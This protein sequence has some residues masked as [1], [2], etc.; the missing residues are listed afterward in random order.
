MV[1]SGGETQSLHILMFPWFA[2]GHI[3]PFLHI[4]NHL[5]S[6]NHRITFLLPNNPSPLFH[7]LNLYPNLISFHFL[8]LPSVPGLPPAAHSASDIPLSLTPLLASAFDLTRP[9][10]H[11]IIHSLRPDFVFFDFA[12]W[13]PDITA[14][15]QIRSICFTV[16]SA[17]S[18]A[19]TV[20]PGRRVSLDHPLTEEDFREP[21]V[22]YP[23]STVVFH[24]SRESRSL[25]FLSMP[26]GQGITFHERLMTSY[27]KSDA[28]AMRTCQE[29]EGDF[30]DFLSN[31]L[32]KKILLTGPLMAAPSSRIKATTL[33][34][35]WEKWLGQFQPKTVI[36]CAF[37]SQVI[38]EKQQLE[39]IVLGI[40]QTGLPF[41]VALKPPMGYD[42]MKEALPKGFEERVKERGI[43]YGGWVQQPLIL[44]HSS[45]GCF[46]SHCGFG[47]MWESLM[48][49]AQIVLIPTLGDQI[50]NTRL[51]AQELKVGVEVKREEDGSFT[52]QSV[53]QAIELVMVDDNNNN[54]SGIGEMV[55]KN[56]AKWKH[57]LTKPGFL[58]TY[59]DNFVKNLQEPWRI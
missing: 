41:L 12:H 15:L 13:I 42:S 52:R 10:V 46:V 38:L 37:G 6:K 29:I 11:R 34:K 59:I 26:F 35:E 49:D 23:S 24:D 53:R 3:T 21:P 55:K 14:P 50:L 8:S 16:V 57:L 36:F 9:Q 45:I 20:F 54:G 48:S 22:G 5:A 17:A 2:T 39:E 51:L 33:D 25:L 27:K 40:E 7:S 28:I 43:V 19:V 4:S 31:Q 30:C 47:S 32:Q 44:N 58:E 56:H 1:R 18:V